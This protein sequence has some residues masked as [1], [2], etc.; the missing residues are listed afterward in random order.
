VRPVFYAS[1]LVHDSFSDEALSD[2]GTIIVTSASSKVAI[3]VAWLLSNDNPRRRIVGVT[4]AG[5]LAFVRGL[6]VYDRVVDY[7]EIAALN[8]EEAIVADMS[9]NA[10]VIAQILAHFGSRIRQR[11][12][13]GYTHR[14]AHNAG[15]VSDP[16]VSPFFVPD[17]M[18]ARVREW[19][20]VE[21][22]CRYDKAFRDFA[23]FSRSWLDVI[24]GRGADAVTNAFHR[25]R[26]NG[27]DPRNG[28]VLSLWQQAR[29]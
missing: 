7:G 15:I 17:R 5:N 26:Q 19:G 11:C 24:E 4:S 22:A 28:H 3:G 1:F 9:G 12:L 16:R 8:R 21:F 20:P 2:A 29:V 23:E 18:R 14:N 25:I 13:V 6:G 27:T 10:K